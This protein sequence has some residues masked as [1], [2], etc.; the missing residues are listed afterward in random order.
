MSRKQYHRYKDKFV[1][2]IASWASSNSWHSFHCEL[3]MDKQ[4]LEHVYMRPEVNS[5][6]FD[7]SNRF[8]KSFCLHGNFTK[9]NLEISNPFQKL[10]RL[11]SDFT[12]VT[13][14]TIEKFLMHMR[15]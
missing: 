7:I 14:Q 1:V 3:K 11:H 10:F 4:G 13:F 8:E 12:A 15:K 9:A 2:C 5:N 6:R